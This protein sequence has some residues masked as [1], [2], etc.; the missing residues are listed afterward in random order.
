MFHT[1][2]KMEKDASFKTIA[3]NFS[4]DFS[5]VESLTIEKRFANGVF[6]MV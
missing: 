5:L 3:V 1:L 6:F 4:F 2:E